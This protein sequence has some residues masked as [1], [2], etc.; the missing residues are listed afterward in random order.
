[1]PATITAKEQNLDKIF[2]D[3]YVFN[4]P[5]YQRPYAWTTEQV[6]ELLD[7]LTD[8]MKRDS[9]PYFLGSV[10]LIKSD[11]DA[12]S[13]VVDGQQRLTTLTMLLCALRDLSDDPKIVQ[14]L[15]KRVWEIGDSLSGNEDRSRL[16]LRE[17]DRNFFQ[18][19]VQKANSL[20]H[21]LKRD[22]VSFSDS[23]KRIFEN[24]KYLRRELLKHN[25]Q[26]R[27]QLAKYI[28]RNCYIVVV[29]ASDVDSAYRIFS[30]MNDRGMPLSPTD[31]L[32]ANII[33]KMPP[34]SR[35]EY[36]ERWEVI[37]EELGR[38]DF[39]DLFA[40]IRTIYRKDKL[41]GSLQKEFQDY[42]LCGL[43][44]KQFIDDVLEPYGDVYATVSM[45]SYKSTE[46]AE[47]LNSLL[48]HLGRLD[49][50]DWI[51]PAMSWFHRREGQTD[52]LFKF[53][54]DLERLAYGLF[55]LRANLNER[56]S[57]YRDVLNAIET[58]ADLFA[59]NSPLQLQS[60]EKEKM[61]DALNSNIYELPRVPMPLLLRLDSLLAEE[62]VI[63]EPSI[64]SIEHVLPQSPTD[65]WIEWFP[66]AEKR[67]GWTHRLANLV[68]L[69][70]RKNTRASNWDFKRK[71]EEYFQ[72]D[73]VTTFALTTQVV[74]ESEWTPEVLECRQERLIDA[75]KKEWRLA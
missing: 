63:A 45:A 9:E 34:D 8:A 41:R 37:E 75:L 7:D 42:V 54:L 25:E 21:F 40:H 11:G 14:E 39:R 15:D 68:L 73:G 4:V 58:E 35:D 46:G 28:I 24:V 10:V 57:R 26:L 56:I 60:K 12:K 65:T 53:T 67:E 32:K 62:G 22:P 64:I 69:S 66:D 61:L 59:E 2:S 16:S 17:R 72:K 31:I 19:H 49:N 43:S 1:M 47:K 13:E 38:D 33:G 70:R 29:S 55:I 23:Q 30:V 52:S 48:K 5:L 36:T 50:F 20:D 3:D 18:Q 44:P 27:H 51:P 71:K 74:N 6:D